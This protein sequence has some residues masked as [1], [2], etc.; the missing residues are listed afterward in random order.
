M[1]GA[2]E[3]AVF[4]QALGRYGAALRPREA[5][6]I[7]LQRALSLADED[8]VLGAASGLED[9]EAEVGDGLFE[10]KDRFRGIG[11]GS[12]QAALLGGPEGEG[13]R[14]IGRRRGLEPPRDLEQPGDAERI[15]VGAGAIDA[16]LRVGRTF[17]IGIPVRA[18]DADLRAASRRVGKEGTMRGRSRW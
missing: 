2:V 16:A 3:E 11:F 12:Q 17:A 14:A 9:V 18:I 10:R 6:E 8:D 4:G 1:V 13:D 15:V 7:I 5:R